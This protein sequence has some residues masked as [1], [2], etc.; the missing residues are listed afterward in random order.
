MCLWAAWFSS[1]ST[2]LPYLSGDPWSQE[3]RLSEEAAVE[4]T[5]ELE[6][7]E[8]IESNIYIIYSNIIY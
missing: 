6:K 4:A 3:T 1:W 2:D 5:T 8:L 7:L